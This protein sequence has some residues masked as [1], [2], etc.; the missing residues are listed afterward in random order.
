MSNHMNAVYD[1]MATTAKEYLMRYNEDF[2]PTVG[3]FAGKELDLCLLDKA[4]NSEE[5]VTQLQKVLDIKNPDFYVLINMAW[6][7]TDDAYKKWGS[8]SQCP[9][10]DKTEMLMIIAVDRSGLKKF[11][12]LEVLRTNNKVSD[13]KEFIKQDDDKVVAYSRFVLKWGNDNPKT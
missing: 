8:P 5:I 6:A 9:L 13:F 11:S 2:P 7:A 1:S 12:A 10:D 4:K 3:L